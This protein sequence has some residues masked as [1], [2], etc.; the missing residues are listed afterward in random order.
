MRIDHEL[1]WN[2]DSVDYGQFPIQKVT[3]SPSYSKQSNKYHR[4]DANFNLC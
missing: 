2:I 4:S 1:I 3:L